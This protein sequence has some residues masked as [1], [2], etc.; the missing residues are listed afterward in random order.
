LHAGVDPLHKPVKH[1]PIR[2]FGQSIRGLR[3]FLRLIKNTRYISADLWARSLRWPAECNRQGTSID[4]VTRLWVSS[5][6]FTC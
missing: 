6:G 5:A 1:F 3:C 2:C 4:R